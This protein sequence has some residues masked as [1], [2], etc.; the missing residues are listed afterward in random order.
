MLIY[1]FMST[2]H[3]IQYYDTL[4]VLAIS[5]VIFLHSIILW[6]PSIN[7]LNLSISHL[8]HLGRYG[9]PVFLLISGALLLGRDENIIIFYKKRIVRIG[10]PLL[11]FIV[12]AYIFNI[13][14]NLFVAFWYC[15]MILGAYLAI[16]F[17]NKI[18]LNSTIREIEY[19]LLIF[20]SSSMFYQIMHALNID[21]A[22]DLNFFIT[23][24]SYLILG[25]YLSR[26]EFNISSNHIV[27][28]SFILFLISTALKIK[29]GNFFD[30][31][32]VAGMYSS[33]DF[34]ILEVIQAGSLFLLVRFIYGDVN[35]ILLKIKNILKQKT[36]NG[37]ILSISKASYGMYLVHM[38]FLK[39]YFRPMAKSLELN[40][41]QMLL[42]SLGIFLF[43]FVS[44][45]LI[46]V[47]LSKIPYLNKFSGYG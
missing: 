33:L 2:K 46:T 14:P 19:F 8:E 12:I 36:V 42:Y 22:L 39:Q 11:F 9:V 7:I 20:I 32:P 3:R 37:M 29:F 34:G 40:N 10:C 25:Y 1:H 21:F 47:I 24:I 15:W 23:P 4:K 30:I 13:Y 17:I 6:N 16:P 27:T 18:I 31:Y 38:L 28:I 44:S 26:K 45:W 35:G 41:S 5:G 43:L